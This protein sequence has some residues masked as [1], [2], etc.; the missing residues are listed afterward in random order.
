MVDVPKVPLSRGSSDPG[1][2]KDRVEPDSQKFKDMMKV[3]KT[4][5]DQQKRQ[6]SREQASK[7]AE[8]N[9]A[10]AAA[11]AKEK[12]AESIQKFD[13]TPKI[14][15][16]GE[17]EKKQPQAQK[18]PEET[19]P[20]MAR[21]DQKRRIKIQQM[22]KAEKSH[23][24]PPK[25]G[26]SRDVEIEIAQEE[27]KKEEVVEDAGTFI[28]EQKEEIRKE[29]ATPAPFQVPAAETLGPL[30]IPAASSVPA[31]YSLLSA[32]AMA[33]FERMVGVISVMT[34]SG[35]TETTIHLN[36]PE[37]QKSIFANC[38]IVIKEYD[39]AQ[40]AFNI[41]FQGTAQ[42]VALFN[43][44]VAGL[45]AAFEGGNY[46]FKINRIEGVLQT[47]EKPLFKRKEHPSQ[48]KEKDDTDT[49]GEL[50]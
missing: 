46:S 31:A 12:P 50:K 28:A 45:M 49:G 9:Q 27:E 6:K 25:S 34:A 23:T 10:T 35:I 41:E 5:A 22:D 13:K 42:N 14:Q 33:L 43:E 29:A 37:F 7:E 4:D 2:S 18:R 24:P 40:K 15:K 17:S 30:F 32:Q 21:V 1:N 44:S 39:T 3:D 26:P 38:T 47:E 8:A 48:K 20:E 36:T 11:A 16:V 19:V